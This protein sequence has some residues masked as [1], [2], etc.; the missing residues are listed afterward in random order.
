MK[1][2]F[3]KSKPD[4]KVFL[5]IIIGTLI[6]LITIVIGSKELMTEEAMPDMNYLH[7]VNI[8]MSMI[9]VTV[10]QING[11]TGQ[12]NTQKIHFYVCSICS[13]LGTM[14]NIVMLFCTNFSI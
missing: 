4:W 9:E 2:R 10:T 3:L 5:R 7:A 1:T 8:K 13:F 6:S 12:I 14:K 11:N